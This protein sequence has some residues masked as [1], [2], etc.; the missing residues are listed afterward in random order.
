M[1]LN[2]R[3]N[4]INLEE[5]KKTLTNHY[6]DKY[7]VIMKGKYVVAVAKTKIIGANVIPT[8][9]KII[10]TGGFPSLPIQLIFTLLFVA[11]GVVI[12][13]ILYF[14]ILHKKMKSIEVEVAD[15]IQKKYSNNIINP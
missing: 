9:N 10:I 7:T 2:I 11:L 8:K 5:L 12:P 14:L 15:F 6:S 4:T 3:E 13:L 1:K